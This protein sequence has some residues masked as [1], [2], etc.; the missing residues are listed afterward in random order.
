MAASSRLLVVLLPGGLLL[1]CLVPLP[2]AAQ[3]SATPAP[4]DDSLHVQWERLLPPLTVT[5]SRLPV[6]PAQAPAR[7]TVIDSAAL[8]RTGAASVASVLEARAGLF[9]RRYG[10]G[11]LATPALRGTGASQTT[12]LLDGQPISDPQ[13]GHLDLSLL[14]TVLLRSVEVMHGPASPLHGSDGLGGAIHL[15]TLRP[16]SS[17]RVRGSA[18]AGAF[19]ERGGSLLVGGP[20]GGRT[21]VLA[22]ADVQTTDGDF[23]YLDKTQFPA[24]TVR[25]RNA[26]R[27]RRSVYGSVRSAAGPHRFR[28][29]GWGTWAER[30]LPPPSSTAPA[31]E[32]QWDTQLRLWGRD[33][34]P[35]GVGQLTVQGLTQHTR[36][37]YAN[38]ARDLDQTGRTWIHSLEA[39]L[40]SVLTD[41]WTGAGGLSGSLARARHPRLKAGAHQEHLAAFAEGTGTYGRLRL[42]PA[43]RADGYWMPDGATRF[44]LSPRLGL[45]WQPV[46]A[47]SSLRLKAQVGRAFRVPTFNDRYW[48]PGGTPDLRPERSWGGDVGLWLGRPQGHVELTAFGHRRRDQIVW[49][50]TGQGYWSPTNVGRVRVLGVEATAA[51]T[52]TLPFG[53]TVTSGLTYTFTDART[54]TDPGTASYN[55][56]LRYVPR[57][58][59]KGHST[60][61]WGPATL[62]V[63]ARYTGRRYVTGDGS[64]FLAPYVMAGTRLQVEHTVAG[65][66]TA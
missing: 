11:G 5:A 19:G 59:L 16:R 43:L 18:H 13:I 52:A 48:Q 60:I 35:V 17:L 53:P 57:H 47:W 61:S 65:V 1:L 58:Q 55:A 33:R 14:P 9:V 21:S 12:L 41:R 46:P 42:Y 8:A 63:H 44:A 4:T 2:G 10:E 28:V 40:R 6:P 25:R 64:Q 30:G 29:S 62:S 20:L 22:A 3:P 49:R 66:R 15:R 7:I 36:L 50:P 34:V 32:R 23:P 39:T 27:V 26:D 45:N 31:G 56:P 24:R 54:R 51:R 38:S 37:R